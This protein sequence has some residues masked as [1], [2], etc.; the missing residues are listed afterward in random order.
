MHPSFAEK[1]RPMEELF[2]ALLSSPVMTTATLPAAVSGGGI[3]LFSDGGIHLYVGR[4]GNLRRRIQEHSRQSSGHNAAPFAF[5]LARETTG[6]LKASYKKQGSRAAL[7]QNSGFADAFSAAKLRIRSMD[8]R[9]IAIEDSVTQCLFE[10]YAS[11]ALGTPY[12]RFENH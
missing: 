8:V 5:S 3:Y 2:Q 10:I 11:L 9:T 7:S 1:L 12:N 4:T 6:N